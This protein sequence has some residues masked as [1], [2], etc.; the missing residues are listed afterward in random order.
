MVLWN[1]AV[2]IPGKGLCLLY[3][4]HNYS[5]TCNVWFLDLVLFD[6][7][8][9]LMDSSYSNGIA[10]LLFGMA[11]LGCVNIETSGELQLGI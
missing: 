5:I 1:I 8:N 2:A 11:F 3:S 9:T 10:G 4:W 6:I 7:K